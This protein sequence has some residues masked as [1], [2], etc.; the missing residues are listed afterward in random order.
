VNKLQ[1]EAHYYRYYLR[2]SKA[3]QDIL[4]DKE[5]R[6]LS[7]EVRFEIRRT[8]NYFQEKV[9]QYQAS[10]REFSEAREA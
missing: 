4:D 9:K 5:N 8:I 2:Q 1:T 3:L 6:N 10:Y 7:M